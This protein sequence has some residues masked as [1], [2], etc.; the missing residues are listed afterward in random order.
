MSDSR[1]DNAMVKVFR[2]WNSKVGSKRKRLSRSFGSTA[3]L[4]EHRTI[5]A[6]D[7]DW[8]LE[9]HNSSILSPTSQQSSIDSGYC[10]SEGTTPRSEGKNIGDETSKAQSN[11][12]DLPLVVYNKSSS[13]QTLPDAFQAWSK[14]P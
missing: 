10:P 5:S 7:Y 6:A 13:P 4:P 2:K 8:D 9:S 11:D 1:G 12:L 3:S 14:C